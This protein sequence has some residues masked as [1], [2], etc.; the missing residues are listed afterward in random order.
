MGLNHINWNAVGALATAAAVIVA[1]FVTLKDTF[2]RHLDRRYASKMLAM[3]M[4]PALIDVERVLRR[5]KEAV[6]AKDPNCRLHYFR[7]DHGAWIELISSK[8]TELLKE[9]FLDR[10]AKL[11][12]HG[13]ER[14]ARAYGLIQSAVTLVDGKVSNEAGERA[15]FYGSYLMLSTAGNHIREVRKI[16]SKTH[17][18]ISKRSWSGEPKPISSDQFFSVINVQ[19][20]P[21]VASEVSEDK[22]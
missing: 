5:F 22:A 2:T 12:E 3:Q 7:Q 11:P 9:A 13:S 10:S 18:E 15:K 16:C 14:V 19:P 17:I 21:G 20:A 6:D 8:N 4:L 1:L